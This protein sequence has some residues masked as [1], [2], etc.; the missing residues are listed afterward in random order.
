MEISIAK[1]LFGHFIGDFFFQTKEMANNKYLSGWKSFWWCNI[2][3]VVYTITVA[4]F[5]GVYSPEFIVGV[6][7]PH[8]IIDRYSLAYRWMKIIGRSYMLE[9]P[10][11]I[12]TSFGAIIYVVTDQT[13]HFICLYLILKFL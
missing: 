12:D 10:K 7:M 1:L 6:F 9:S 11:P 5:A 8:W 2:H 13:L 4:V 3:V